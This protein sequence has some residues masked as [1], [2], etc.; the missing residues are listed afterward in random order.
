MATPV[1][2]KNVAV[3]MESGIAAAKTISGITKASPGVASSTSHGYS[4][5][6]IIILDIVGMLQLNGKVVRVA[7]VTTDTFALEGVDTTNFDTFTSG[8]AQKLTLGTS[9]TTATTI[10][11]SG[12]DF[13]FIDVTTIHDNA[14]KQV[15]GL[16]S[17]VS[18]QFDN[19]WDA[20]DAGLLAMKAASDIQAKKA[21]KF[22]FGTGGKV[23]YFAGYVGCSMLPGGTAQNLVTTNAVITMNGTPTYYAS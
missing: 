22:Q 23:L 6:D 9:I 5:G 21:F 18:Y 1:V 14:K 10:N 2:W 4:N 15:P 8:T 13:D 11:S 7:S 16:P 17:A 12:G 3:S 20:A 19:I